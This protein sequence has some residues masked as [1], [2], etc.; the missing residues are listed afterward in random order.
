MT[1]VCQLYTPSIW[2]W[3]DSSQVNFDIYTDVDNRER[4][5]AR[6]EKQRRLI[7]LEEKHETLTAAVRK[8]EMLAATKVK[9]SGSEEEANRNTYDTS[10][11]KLV[12]N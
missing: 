1:I 2:K 8:W 9:T 6:D 7:S 5:R 3:F 11:I 12:F 10:S 4:A